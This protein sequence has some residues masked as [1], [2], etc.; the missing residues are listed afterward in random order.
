MR[1]KEKIKKRLEG[2]PSA[3]GVYLFRDEEGTLLYIG[4]ALDLRKRVPSYF[5]QKADLGPKTRHL[6]SQ[7]GEIE[8][9][10][11]DSEMEALLLEADLIKRLKPRYNQRWKDDKSYPVLE[12][13]KEDFPRVRLTRGGSESSSVFGPFPKMGAREIKKSLRIL[14]PFRDCSRAKFE[15]YEDL[16]RGCLYQN[17][18]LCP[19]P[20]V[21]ALSEKQY[22]GQIRALKRFLKGKG[23][24]GDL[25]EKMEKASRERNFERAA[26]LRDRWKALERARRPGL[27]RHFEGNLNLPADRRSGELGALKKILGLEKRPRRIEAY[28]VSGTGGEEKTGSMVVFESARVRKSDYRKFKIKS[29]EGVDDPGCL[30]EVLVRRLAYLEKEGTGDESFGTVPDLILVD[31]GKGQLSAAQ[32]ALEKKGMEIPVAALAKRK[33]SLY[34]GDWEE[35]SLSGPEEEPALRLVQRIRD[36]SHRFALSYHR[37]LREKESLGRG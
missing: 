12:I 36:E 10:K 23:E 21:G 37:K 9:Q 33:E 28:D 17:L 15:R 29:V 5:H 19:A 1:R 11:T 24:I 7:I 8:V 35:S 32:G 26:R 4:K 18:G 6:V 20:C 25:K 22:A 14:F 13:G 30:R 27:A 34:F 31:G 2:L 3:S 16:G